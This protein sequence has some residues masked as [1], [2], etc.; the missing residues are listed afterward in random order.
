MRT[1]RHLKETNGINIH[2]LL[3]TPKVLFTHAIPCRVLG[4]LGVRVTLF[5]LRMTFQNTY[6]QQSTLKL[7]YTHLM[8]AFFALIVFR[9][10][11]FESWASVPL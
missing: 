11:D 10:I 2:K 4:G 8:S 9:F 7:C 6:A 1:L 3:R 5:R